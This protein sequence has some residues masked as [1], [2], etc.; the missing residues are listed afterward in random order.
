MNVYRPDAAP[1]HRPYAIAHRPLA[2][3]TIGIGKPQGGASEARSTGRASLPHTLNSGSGDETVLLPRAEGEHLTRVLRLGAGDT[4]TVFDG[5][6]HEFVGRVMSAIRRDVRVQIVS[7][8]DAVA[9]SGVALTLAQGVLKGD[10]MDDVIRDAVMLGAFAIQPI[11][12]KRSETTVAALMR[13][14]SSSMFAS[15]DAAL[16]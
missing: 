4:V 2:I 16:R 6:G 14:A 8:L 5:R 1:H 9:E 3:N 13:G 11:V 15:M 7:P 10:K 12:T